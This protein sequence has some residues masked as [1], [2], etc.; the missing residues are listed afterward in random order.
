MADD[1]DRAQAI[2]ERHL[3]TA[4]EEI[5]H[6]QPTGESLEFCE[7]CQR[8]IPENRRLAVPGCRKC[9]H[10]QEQ[11]ELLSHWRN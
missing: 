3:E 5:R 6:N 1:I 9:I 7:S 2:N 8:T 11:S 10:C 4:L